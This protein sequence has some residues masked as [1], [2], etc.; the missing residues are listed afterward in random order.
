MAQINLLP[1]EL[2]PKKYVLKASKSLNKVATGFM[3]LFLIVITIV[4][5]GY[6]VLSSQ[7][8]SAKNKHDQLSTEIKALSESEQRM[9]LVK[10]RIDKINEVLSKDSTNEELN[11]MDNV[12]RLA[13][14]ELSVDEVNLDLDNVDFIVSTDTSAKMT[15]FLA[16][17]ITSDDYKS[18]ELLSLSYAPQTGYKINLNVVK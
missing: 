5:G 4:I 14:S 12:V 3:V 2:K 17:L 16:G 18:M 13:G 6:L 9:V 7:V 1:E 11:V 10:D 8:T 15:K